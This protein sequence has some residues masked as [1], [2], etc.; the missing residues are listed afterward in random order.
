MGV[1]PSLEK[2]MFAYIVMW[3]AIVIIAGLAVAL[4]YTFIKG[5]FNNEDMD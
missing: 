2:T 4:A 1:F 3:I 5:D